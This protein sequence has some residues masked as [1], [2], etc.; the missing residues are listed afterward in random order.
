MA[1]E[2]RL[3]IEQERELRRQQRHERGRC[4]QANEGSVC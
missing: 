3:A 4:N 1:A 2:N